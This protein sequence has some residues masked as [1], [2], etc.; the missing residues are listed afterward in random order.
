MKPTI[1]YLQIQTKVQYWTTSHQNSGPGVSSI[2][3]QIAHIKFCFDYFCFLESCSIYFSHSNLN[4]WCD[5]E[6]SVWS[7]T[8]D[9]FSFLFDWIAHLKRYILMETTPKSDQWF[10]IYEQFKDSQNNRK[11]KAFISFSGYISQ[12]M[13]PTSDWFH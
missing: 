8:C 10:H 6:K 2:Y 9:I 4:M 3:M 13:L 11:Q 12:S 7:R 5:L 1:E